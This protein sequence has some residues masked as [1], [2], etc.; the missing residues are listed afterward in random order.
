M[1]STEIP[2]FTTPQEEIQYWKK[3]VEDKQQEMDDLETTFTEFQDFSKQ[4]EEEMEDELRIC[5]KKCADLAS[6]YARLKNDHETIVDKLNT[7]NKES[8]KL[9]NSLQ[10]EVTKLQT[11]KQSLLED[12]RRLEQDNDSLERRERNSSASVID[13]SDKLDR[14]MEENVWMQSEL[15]ESKQVADETIQRLRDDIR[16]LRHELSVRER[17]PSSASNSI[18]GK[19]NGEKSINIKREN[20]TAYNIPRAQKSQRQ[21]TE[22]TASSSRASSLV[23]VNDLINLVT[24]LETRISNFKIKSNGG[25][26]SSNGQEIGT[27]TSPVLKHQNSFTNLSDFKTS[28]SPPL[29]IIS[30]SGG[31]NS[32]NNNNNNNNNNSNSTPTGSLLTHFENTKNNSF[33]IN[34]T[35][36]PSNNNSPF[37]PNFNSSSS[38]SSNNTNDLNNNNK[39]ENVQT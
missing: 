29:D 14:V 25:N 11:T 5:E 21:R 19:S 16:D 9:I 17:K 28:S 23:V 33:D 34:S 10:D 7:T 30:S 12:K 8:S 24:D 27:P 20:P 32:N 22:D 3:R 38:G 35:N 18:N 26:V 36:I 13:L 2:I 4:L 31:S 15:E 39:N 6:L 37:K 1:A